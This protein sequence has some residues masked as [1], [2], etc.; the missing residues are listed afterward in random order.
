MN[1]I[2]NARIIILKQGAKN[3]LFSCLLFYTVRGDQM[4]QQPH[5]IYLSAAKALIRFSRFGMGVVFVVG[6]GVS[7]VAGAQATP[8]DC[9]NYPG[10]IPFEGSCRTSGQIAALDRER[11]CGPK[12]VAFTQAKK[13][14]SIACSEAGIDDDDCERKLTDCKGLVSDQEYAEEKC[15][16][17]STDTFQNRL[18]KLTSNLERAVEAANKKYEECEEKVLKNSTDLTAMRDKFIE[19]TKS[20]TELSTEHDK[21]VAELAEKEQSAQESA[22]VEIQKIEVKIANSRVQVRQAQELLTAAYRVQTLKSAQLNIK[23]TCLVRANQMAR[24]LVTGTSTKNSDGNNASKKAPVKASG[25]NAITQSRQ[26]NEIAKNEYNNCVQLNNLDIRKKIDSAQDG[27]DAA[28]RELRQ[29]EE[30]KARLDS[31]IAQLGPSIEAGKQKL[32][33]AKLEAEKNIKEEINQHNKKYLQQQQQN[34]QIRQSCEKQVTSLNAK[35]ESESKKLSAYEVKNPGDDVKSN[36]RTVAAKWQYQDD[37]D[38]EA[39]ACIQS[40]E[41]T[42]ASGAPTTPLPAGSQSTGG[43]Q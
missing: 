41:K 23:Y 25:A 34:E 13:E 18:D 7:S 32:E 19:L 16:T 12:L 10:T 27:V 21:S 3:W 5:N 38:K 26:I 6:I 33:A 8:L 11:T 14:Y 28:D 4:N 42:N 35:A 40:I 20:L 29:L 24:D 43:T 2:S 1:S 39:K 9:K 31:K 15:P 17:I 37:A 36:W 22:F 30:Q